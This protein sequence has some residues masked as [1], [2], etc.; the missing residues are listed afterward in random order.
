MEKICNLTICPT[1]F[2]DNREPV[3]LPDTLDI[4]FLSNYDLSNI[5]VC[6]RNGDKEDKIKAINGRI[7]LDAFLFAGTIEINVK[8][9]AKGEVV[10]EWELVPILVKEYEGTYQIKDLLK[11]IEDRLDVLEQKTTI[12]M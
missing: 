1:S 7:N 4:Q 9:L 6:V 2:F 10:K 11:D 12:I 5:L 8:M 3:V